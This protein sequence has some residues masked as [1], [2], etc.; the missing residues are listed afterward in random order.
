MCTAITL[1]HEDMLLQARTM[2]FPYDVENT[3]V[4]IPRNYELKFAYDHKISKHHAIIGMSFLMDNK[5]LCDG[6]NEH[7]LSG[8]ALYFPDY[9]YYHHEGDYS[10]VNIAGEDLLTYILANATDINGVY[11]LLN[12][13]HLMDHQCNLVDGCLPLHWIFSDKD[14]RSI[15]IEPL[16]EGLKVSNNEVGVLSNSP[17]YQWH[18]TNLNNYV[19]LDFIDTNVK[20]IE[21]KQFKAFGYQGLIG[22]PGD[23]GSVSRFIRTVF[24]KDNL[25]I[26]NN[27]PDFILAAAH[28]LNNVDVPKWSDSNFYTKF[29]SYMMNKDCSYYFK[30]YDS[31]KI[32]RVGFDEFDVLESNIVLIDVKV[33]KRITSL[34]EI[35]Y[36]K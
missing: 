26:V 7:G 27:E 33:T 10:K 24:N 35:G 6:I 9:A 32:I 3:L 1:N 23:F 25:A 34:K 13:I 30:T 18:L 8:S 22:L 28:L 20:K 15:I 19:N 14:G 11:E 5:A 29:T 16:K 21:S 31:P 12:G 36:T 4:F 2:D 17:D